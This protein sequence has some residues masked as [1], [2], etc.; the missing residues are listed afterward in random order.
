M[1]VGGGGGGGGGGDSD[2]MNT[3]LAAENDRLWPSIDIRLQWS[4]TQ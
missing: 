2:P 1:C 3:C 4:R